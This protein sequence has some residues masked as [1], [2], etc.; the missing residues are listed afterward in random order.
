MSAPQQIDLNDF[1]GISREYLLNYLVFA[2][3]LK[4]LD[5]ERLKT[6]IL[7]YFISMK[8]TPELLKQLDTANKSD[9][10]QEAV[11]GV[12]ETA[13]QDK[14]EPSVV[15][16]WT[17]SL[18]ALLDPVRPENYHISF[19]FFR[20]LLFLPGNRTAVLAEFRTAPREIQNARMGWEDEDEVQTGGDS[21]G[22][23][24][25]GDSVDKKRPKKIVRSIP[26]GGPW[27]AVF[28]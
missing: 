22:E 5:K 28:L 24:T 4:G 8:C 1:E 13:T 10:R 12:I 18:P 26:S 7:S 17:E 16:M 14:L 9:N 11:I 25:V 6:L 20:N 23:E 21:V 15:A 19:D 2:G 3:P 27:N